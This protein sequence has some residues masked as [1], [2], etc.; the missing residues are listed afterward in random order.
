MYPARVVQP[1]KGEASMGVKLREGVV[2]KVEA[3]VKKIPFGS[4]Y[5]HAEAFLELANRYAAQLSRCGWTSKQT[6]RLGGETQRLRSLC[7][8]QLIGPPTAVLSTKQLTARPRHSRAL[9]PR[10]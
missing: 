10:L 4:I 2:G 3:S 5:R 1:R 8:E 9:T 6:A 7:S